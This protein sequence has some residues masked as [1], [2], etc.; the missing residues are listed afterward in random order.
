VFYKSFSNNILPVKL[1]RNLGLGLAQRLTPIRNKVM[2][3]AM[4]LEG[5]RLPKLAK[6]QRITLHKS[7]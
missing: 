4:G 1:V 7:V 5:G 6:G 3:A 2:R